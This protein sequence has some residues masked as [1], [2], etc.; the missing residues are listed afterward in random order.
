MLNTEDLS[1]LE[2]TLWK[3]ENNYRFNSK[4]HH[5]KINKKETFKNGLFRGTWMPQSVKRPNSAQI[6]IS[7]FES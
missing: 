6:M 5:K 7:R 4:A 1:M 3:S 2:I